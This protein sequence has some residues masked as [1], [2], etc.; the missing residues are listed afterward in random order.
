MNFVY[1]NFIF[2]IFIFGCTNNQL[3]KNKVEHISKFDTLQSKSNT[4]T[5]QSATVL[6]DSLLYFKCKYNFNLKKID[7]LDGDFLTITNSYYSS[8]KNII[9]PIEKEVIK[10]LKNKKINCYNIYYS[11]VCL[12]FLP[13]N[14]KVVYGIG[15]DFSLDQIIFLSFRENKLVDAYLAADYFGDAD[16]YSATNSEFLENSMNMK[17]I[18]L[19]SKRTMSTPDTLKIIKANYYSVSFK[20][21]YFVEKLDSTRENFR[22][23]KIWKKKK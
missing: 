13:P 7:V 12:S 18:Y 17:K 9:Y 6:R 20:N 2:F 8:D 23:V 22:E 10:I 3:Q 1:V 4:V 15:G 14:V 21:G 16:D 19:D 5:E 11:D